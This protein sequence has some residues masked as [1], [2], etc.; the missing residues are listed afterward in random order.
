MNDSNSKAFAL[1]TAARCVSGWFIGYLISAASSFLLLQ[2]S[3]I[4]PEK[5]ASSTAV[6]FWVAAFGVV[7]TLAAGWIGACFS[8]RNGLGIG[9]SI[10]LTIAFVATASWRLTP[11]HAHWTQVIALCAMIPAAILGG[12]IRR[13]R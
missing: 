1:L 12:L 2:R 11:G 4:D 8:R 5:P 13:K 9:I 3:G 6:I 7:F 10:G